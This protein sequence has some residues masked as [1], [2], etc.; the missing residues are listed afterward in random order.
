MPGSDL[1]L[2]AQWVFPLYHVFADFAEFKGGEVT[3]LLSDLPLRFDGLI[4]RRGKRCTLLLANLEETPGK[5]R[6]EGI[7]AVQGIR[8]LNE[9]TAMEAMSDPEGFRARP[10]ESV[11]QTR[12]GSLDLE[13]LPFELIRLELG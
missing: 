9:K 3:D 7:G 6:L 1:R 11:A 8:R 5:V 4:L 12:V 10:F 13:L 2:N